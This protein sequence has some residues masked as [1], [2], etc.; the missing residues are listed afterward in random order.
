MIMY[1]LYRIGY[2]LAHALPV[3]VSYFIACRIADLQYAL[4]SEERNAVIKNLKVVTAGKN[5]DDHQIA[6]MARSIFRNFAKYLV[7]FFR[8]PRI[9]DEYVKKFIKVEG[10]ENI[11]AA[12]KSNKGVIIL[13]AHIGNWELGGLMVSKLG[14]RLSAVVL[15]HKNKKINDF[16]TRQRMVGNVRPIEIG[17]SLRS[18]YRVLR[19][20]GCLALLGDRDFFNNGIK[21]NFFKEEATIPR[22]PAFFSCRIGSPMVPSFMIREDDDTFKLIFEKPIFPPENDAHPE[23]IK[24]VTGLYLAVLEKYI[25]KYP[26]QWYAFREVWSDKK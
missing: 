18:C 2:A 20:N 14:Y 22:G 11:R 10:I 26:T 13:S 23:S 16:F 25:N 3:K 15:T 4:G 1:L 5:L 8:F 17:L 6:D 19:G 9:N 7:D 24:S 21:I 12:E